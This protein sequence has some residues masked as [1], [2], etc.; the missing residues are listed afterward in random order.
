M[1]C[2]S[3]PLAK[4]KEN[5]PTAATTRARVDKRAAAAYKS[6]EAVKRQ[7]TPLTTMGCSP[8]NIRQ[9]ILI[10]RTSMNSGSIDNTSPEPP[11]P[12]AGDTFFQEGVEDR[13]NANLDWGCDRWKIYATGYKSAADI[14]VDR[15]LQCQRGDDFIIYPIPARAAGD[16]LIYPIA[17]LYRHSLELQLKGLIIAGQD[18]LDQK[19][20]LQHVHRLDLLWAACRK[21]LE[22]VWPENSSSD[23]DAVE[24]CIR[25]VCQTD[26]TSISF[27]Y[28]LTKEG[29]PT[30]DG[31]GRVSIANLRDVMQRVS[32]LFEG[33]SIGI[34]AYLDTKPRN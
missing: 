16:F 14:L 21:I 6:S 9:P 15:F 17:F 10:C 32:A 33:A 24:G 31:M 25:D 27:R 2:Q 34:S 29:K 22:S 4:S 5:R 3:F 19:P 12:K 30:L 18:L 8:V 13:H 20:D 1:R 28:P 23:L 26:P 11:W 7:N